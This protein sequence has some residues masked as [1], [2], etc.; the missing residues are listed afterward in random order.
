MSPWAVTVVVGAKI[1]M[2]C[3]TRAGIWIGT[4]KARG[5][6][7]D[8]ITSGTNAGTEAVMEVSD[9]LLC[10]FNA[11]ITRRDDAVV[12]SIP[13]REIETGNIDP[14]H[15]YRIA[16][17]DQ[18]DTGKADAAGE[19]PEYSPTQPQPPVEEGEIRYVEIEDRGKQGDGIARVERGYVIIVPGA[20]IGDRV[21]IEITG[22][23]SNFAVGE[24][25]EETFE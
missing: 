24:I 23:K 15:V 3:V 4:K 9:T 14:E 17:M 8:F 11:E 25:V 5:W 19:R 22:V 2:F 1:R 20:D 13:Q 16:I 10:L 12:V 21:K 7:A 18:G 6:L